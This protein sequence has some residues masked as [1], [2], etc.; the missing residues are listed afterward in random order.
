MIVVWMTSPFRF[1]HPL[2]P[3][4]QSSTPLTPSTQLSARNFILPHR[5]LSTPASSTP[6]GSPPTTDDIDDSYGHEDLPRKKTRYSSFHDISSDDDRDGEN[7]D[8]HPPSLLETPVTKRPP[9]I[10]PQ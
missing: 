5:R 7:A 8:R 1:K 9:V 2:P 6:S 3:Q 10:L 4:T